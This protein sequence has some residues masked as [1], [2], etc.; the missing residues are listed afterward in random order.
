ME[1]NP[2]VSLIGVAIPTV[3]NV[4]VGFETPGMICR[5]K[6]HLQ[7]L[8]RCHFL[9]PSKFA[10]A[11]FRLSNAHLAVPVTAVVVLTTIAASD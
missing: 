10:I 4:R 2:T 9:A 3:L 6:R 7:M 11:R 5:P 8:V 1:Q